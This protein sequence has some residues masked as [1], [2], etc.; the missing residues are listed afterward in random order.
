MLKELFVFV[1]GLPILLAFVYDTGQSALADRSLSVLEELIEGPLFGSNLVLYFDPSLDVDFV[2]NFVTLKVFR[3]IS[4]IHVDLGSNG[5][6]WS[7]KQP[8]EVLRGSYY[9]HI[10]ICDTDITPFFE[11][12][13]L[14]WNPKYILIYSLNADLI[15]I[16]QEKVFQGIE[17]LAYMS[18]LPSSLNT[19]N[20]RIGLY[21]YFPFFKENSL[22]LLGVWNKDSYA[23]VENIFIDRYQSFEGAVF[24]LG[25]WF[26]DFPYLYQSKTEPEGIGEG[27]EVEMLDAIAATLNF[28]YTLT[29]EPPD[30]KWG[31]FVN[32]TWTGMLGMVHR[33]DKNFTINYFVITSER[34]KAFD[35]TVSYWMEGFGMSMMSPPPLPKWR[36]TYYSFRSDVWLG[37]AVTYILIVLLMTIQ[38]KI[39]EKPFFGKRTSKW[40]YFVQALVNQGMT[41]LPRA[42][43]QRVFIGW[44]LLYCFIVTIAYTANL[45]AFLTIPVFPE[46]V[47]TVQQLAESDY[48]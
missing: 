31:A 6:I 2:N 22:S 10:I 23:N 17:R 40:V 25:T 29:T 5:S 44:W 39:Q 34:V 7:Q 14:E 41:K 16:L 3:Y 37:I 12:V 36:G 46:R 11:S 33:K 13:S 35:A 20:I 24:H 32:G 4:L 18:L 1:L 21:T 8:L 28:S 38:D 9:I 30:L 26:D 43:W 15:W 45:I 19:T 48:G 42:Q 27:V 47:Q